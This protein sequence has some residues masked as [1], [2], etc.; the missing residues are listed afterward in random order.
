[1]LITVRL[2]AILRERAGAKELTL[3]LAD[4][5]CVADALAATAD[6]AQG[7]PLVLA[8][9]RVYASADLPLAAGD[10]LALIPPVSGGAGP[11][12]DPGVLTPDSTAVSIELSEQPLRPDALLAAVRDSRAGAIVLF[13]G[14]TREVAQLDYEAYDQMAVECMREIAE[15]A[16]ARHGCCR[17]AVA[18]RTGTVA[19]SEPSVLV[20]ASAA[21]RGEAFAA[22]REVIDAVKAQAPIW[23]RETEDGISTWTAGRPPAV[24]GRP[25]PAG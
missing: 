2:F 6:L 14:V 15:R 11:R 13:E 25:T 8:V 12:E 7:L 9:N 22:A 18:H 17:V 1:M 23:K 20:A 4:D 19:L 16:L 5:A 10:E 21:H 3:E 24:Q